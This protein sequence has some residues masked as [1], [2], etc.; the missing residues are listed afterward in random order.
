MKLLS[1][2]QTFQISVSLALGIGK[3][4]GEGTQRMETV[5]IDEG[6]GGLD[7]KRRQAMVQ[8]LQDLQA[9]LKCIIVVSHQADFYEQFENR[10]YVWLEDNCS[11]VSLCDEGRDV[12]EREAFG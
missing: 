4:A 7:V 1:G 9:M 5:L 3:Y 12:E 6:F 2:G 10:Y 11:K 8:G